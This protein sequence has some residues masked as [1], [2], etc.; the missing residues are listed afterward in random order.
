M[1]AIPAVLLLG[2]HMLIIFLQ[3]P[4][5]N[6]YDHICGTNFPIIGTV[7]AQQDP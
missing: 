4:V 2:M 3:A 7:T 1:Q 6:E 5:C